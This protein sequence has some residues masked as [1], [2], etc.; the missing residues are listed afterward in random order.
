MTEQSN[1]DMRAVEEILAHYDLGLLQ[2]VSPLT[3]G[4]VQTNLLLET[5]TGRYV[6]RLYRQNRS[7]AAVRFEVDVG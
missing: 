1:I 7:F 4:T 2:R 5:D 6:L 3:A